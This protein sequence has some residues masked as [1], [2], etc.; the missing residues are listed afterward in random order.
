MEGSSWMI[1]IGLGLSTASMAC[2]TEAPQG[3]VPARST[4]T[5][6]SAPAPPSAAP[7]PSAA[8]TTP[9]PADGRFV[10]ERPGEREG[11]DACA[12]LGGMGFACVDAII[13]EKDPV[14]RR[15][16][17]RLSDAEARLA[18]DANEKG[19]WGGVAHAEV[20]MF[21]DDTGPCGKKGERD[22]G[23]A[24]LTKAEMILHENKNPAKAKQ[25]QARACKCDPDRAQIPVPGGALACDGPNKPVERGKN[26]DL[27]EAREIR[28]CAECDAEA[29][30]KA[31]EKEI[32]RLRAK[33][34]E[35]AAYLE[36]THLP[37]CQRP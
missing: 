26:L 19:P 2:A 33:D 36:T 4:P 31:C 32:G 5:V 30:P 8:P 14:K 12:Y 24:C 6:A 34:P 21:C 1:V 29:G 7:A 35:I 16:M 25:A 11:V 27:Q 28:A 23:Y 10:R 13:A 3:A 22:D 15:Y 20:S 17:R 18:R 37:R 9:A